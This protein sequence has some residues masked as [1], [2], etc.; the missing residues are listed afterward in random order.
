MF[1]LYQIIISILIIISPFVILFRIFKNKE[2]K[3]RFIEKFSIPT[4]KRKKGKLIWFH[5]A[6]VGEILSIIPIIKYYEK[7]KS[8]SQILITSSTLSSSKVFKKFNFKKSIHQFYPIDHLIFANKFL[9]YW[10]PNIAIFIESEIWPTM[11]NK[12][13]IK[14]IPLI[15]LNARLTKKSYKRW[16]KVKNFASTIFDKISVAFP[17]NLDIKSFL[18]KINLTKINM[19]GNIKFAEN[20]EIK[21]DKMSPKLKSEFKKRNIWVASSTHES[22]EIF[23]SKAHIKLK[24]KIKNLITIIIPRHVHRVNKIINDLENLDLKI[25]THSSNKNN[26]KN[27]DIYIVDTFGETRKFHSLAATVFLGGSIIKRGGQ[28][29]LEAARYGANILHGPNI[30]NFS[31]VYKQ[32]SFLNVSKKIN[33][34]DQLASKIV[35]KKNKFIGIKIKKIGKKILKK[36]INQL[37]NLINDEFKK[38]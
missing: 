20:S 27:V 29:P 26:L 5:A 9:N 19:I 34:P 31:D 37:D 22:E 32:L 10:Q 35:F 15:L 24:K 3:K 21:I 30:S 33:T 7:E 17:Q 1:L 4:I 16:M 23:C 36:T 38:T 12:L 28:N 25:V 11:Y 13:Y 8:V 2:D 14:K 6:S 18:K